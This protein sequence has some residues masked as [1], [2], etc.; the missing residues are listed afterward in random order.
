[1]RISL[2]ASFLQMTLTA[3][4]EYILVGFHLT[5]YIF[6]YIYRVLY[7]LDVFGHLPHANQ[8]KLCIVLRRK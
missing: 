7:F 5:K 1:M 2:V 3:T 8:G 6:S 4:T